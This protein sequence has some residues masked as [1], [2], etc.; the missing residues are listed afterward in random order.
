M[1]FF[2]FV[3]LIFGLCSFGCSKVSDSNEPSEEESIELRLSASA[4]SEP[5]LKSVS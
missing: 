4:Y 1:Q 5:E 2:Y 3:A